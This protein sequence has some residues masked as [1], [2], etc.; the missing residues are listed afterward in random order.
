[1][2]TFRF[3]NQNPNQNNKNY[4]S[5]FSTDPCSPNIFASCSLS[6]SLGMFPTQSLRSTSDP[7]AASAVAAETTS[8]I[9]LGFELEIGKIEGRGLREE[10]SLL[11]DQNDINV[12]G[13][14][15]RDGTLALL[16]RLVENRE[17][18]AAIFK[19]KKKLG[20]FFFIGF[21]GGQ[22]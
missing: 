5:A 15:G 4:T 2:Q 16:R 6:T 20:F 19:P 8:L 21:Q 12:V 11:G 18:T 17:E 3:K 10:A 22:G 1:M 7:T 9:P 13:N 14:F